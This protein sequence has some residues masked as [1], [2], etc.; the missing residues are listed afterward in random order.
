MLGLAQVARRSQR[1]LKTFFRAGKI[2]FYQS[3]ATQRQPRAN[4]L[5]E[6][7]AF[8]RL[9]MAENRRLETN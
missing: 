4:V 8:A 9:P 2:I 5:A 7:S 3:R 1:E 6:W